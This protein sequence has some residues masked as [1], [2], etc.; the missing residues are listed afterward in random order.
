MRLF[1]STQAPTPTIS[2]AVSA[3]ET[4]P[5]AFCLDTS[6]NFNHLFRRFR[7]NDD[8]MRL[9]VST[10][11]PTSTISSAV[12]AVGA[13]PCAFCLDTSAD[14]NHLFCRLRRRG[15]AMHRLG[16]I[17]APAARSYRISFFQVAKEKAAYGI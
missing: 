10:Q 8:A 4:M 17:P 15:D 2:S 11:V 16:S 12:S 13:M 1:V 5:C 3:V 7:R 6:A 9:F 14:F